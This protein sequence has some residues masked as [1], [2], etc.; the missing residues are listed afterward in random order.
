VLFA[1]QILSVLVTKERLIVFN[2][3][4]IVLTTNVFSII[5][6]EWLVGQC[7]QKSE[8]GVT[9]FIHEVKG[10]MFVSAATA[11]LI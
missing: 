3:L 7:G 5:K 9:V 1:I 4:S 2:K 11:K 6:P 8:A 10:T